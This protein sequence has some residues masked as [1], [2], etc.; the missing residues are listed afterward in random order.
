MNL[1]N[2]RHITLTEQEDLFGTIDKAKAI[3]SILEGYSDN[4]NGNSMFALYGKWGSGK[5]SVLKYLEKHLDKKKYKSLFFDTWEYEKDDNIPLSL[6]S[7]ISD[8]LPANEQFKKEVFNT[9]R[10]LFKSFFRGISIKL[11][12]GLEFSNERYLNAADQEVQ[13]LADNSFHKS[14]QTFVSQFRDLE[15]KI[16]KNRTNQKLIVFIDDID[17]CEPDN[18]LS[19]ISAIKLFFTYGEKTIFLFALDEQAVQTAIKTKYKEVV[20]ADEYLEKVFDM[21]FNMPVTYSTDRL[22]ES[23][24]PNKTQIGTEFHADANI[25]SSFFHRLKIH[26]PRKIKKIINKLK[27]LETLKHYLPDL[28]LKLIPNYEN[29]RGALQEYILSLYFITLYEYEYDKFE[30]LEKYDEKLIRYIELHQLYQ[31]GANPHVFE[32]TGLS[33]NKLIRG[34]RSINALTTYSNTSGNMR[35]NYPFSLFLSLFLPKNLSKENIYIGSARQDFTPTEIKSL[36]GP[37]ILVDFS[38]FII[39]NEQLFTNVKSEYD[40]YNFYQMV[41]QL[42]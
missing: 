13:A 36:H 18:V 42:L 26:N 20:K 15:N 4:L 14:K 29:D 7:N 17:R 25:I 1:L 30:E 23:C 11:P 19:L 5:S 8:L 31:N 38:N 33:Q 27:T 10:V 41:K 35:F 12:I 21:T 28:K 24:F 39:D 9:S 40:F 22:M 3:Q 6:L 2:N 34:K 37:D 16:L 32:L